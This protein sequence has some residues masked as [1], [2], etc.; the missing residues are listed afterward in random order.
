M[1]P[2]VGPVALVLP[3]KFMVDPENEIAPATVPERVG[4]AENT[5]FVEVVPV[6]PDADNPVMLLKQEIDAEEQFVP[7]FATGKTPV[8]PLVRLT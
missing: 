5:R 2:V 4:D 7:P 6:V 8:T 1:V 3:V